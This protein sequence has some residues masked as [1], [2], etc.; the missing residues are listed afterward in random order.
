MVTARRLCDA[1][2]MLDA[3]CRIGRYEVLD[4]VG[5][6]GLASVYRVRHVELGSIFALKLLEV[7]RPQLRARLLEEGRAQASLVH[8]NVVR[9]SDVLLYEGMPVLL[10]EF[11]EGPSLD[12]LLQSGRLDLG[13]AL[14]IA[15]GITR[16]LRAAH[17]RGLVH[18]DLKPS[19]VL[20]ARTA[21]GWLPKL[22]DF[23]L[24]KVIR[25]DQQTLRAPTQAGV[26]MGTPQFMAPEQ[27]R[28]AANVDHRADLYSLGC[29]LY[30][31]LT[32]T[33]PFVGSDLLQLHDQI[34][35]G[36]HPPSVR[37]PELPRALDRL[38]M[39]LLKAN[40]AAR[41]I[42]C[43]EVLSVLE[44]HEARA[45]APAIGRPS[46]L[47]AAARDSTWGGPQALRDRGFSRWGL[48][49]PF[50]LLPVWVAAGSQLAP[51]EVVPVPVPRAPLEVPVLIPAPALVPVLPEPLPTQPRKPSPT[52]DPLPTVRYQGDASRVWLVR[53][54]QRW[55]LPGEI[56]PGDY[57]VVALFPG[58]E[59]VPT[60]NV[61]VGPESMTLTCSAFALRCLSVRDK[62]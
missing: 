10:M 1:L 48:G 52:A 18:R 19:N 55:D 9:V 34:L 6:G 58:T 29:L 20:L 53:D 25:E 61:T 35:L 4:R 26:A 42:S 13:T 5:Q 22:A 21:A 44:S 17:T 45:L 37:L 7:H 57:E 62:N 39:R 15:I 8:P 36:A 16:G 46:D 60:G 11:V 24:V 56:A 33:M 59:P 51:P 14:D 40:P 54:G 28:D 2:R 31:L 43:G 12:Q 32:G 50:L 27:I 3:G 23:G 49:A 30:L 47:Q 38:V 41:P